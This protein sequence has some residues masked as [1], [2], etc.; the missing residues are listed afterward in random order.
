[1][2]SVV[3]SDTDDGALKVASKPLFRQDGKTTMTNMIS[4]KAGPKT[5]AAA[6]V[7]R[8][9]KAFQQEVRDNTRAAADPFLSF[10]S[11]GSRSFRAIAGI[12]RKQP[13]NEVEAEKDIAST[14][15]KDGESAKLQAAPSLVAYDSD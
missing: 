9:R 13:G 5:K 12:K 14:R 8:R 7:E 3:T 11:T 15:V 10:G 4:T 6:E 1:M 2:A